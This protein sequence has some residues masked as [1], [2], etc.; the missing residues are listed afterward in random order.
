MPVAHLRSVRCRTLGAIRCAAGITPAQLPAGLSLSELRPRAEPP[1][2]SRVP[3][4]LSARGRAPT[5]DGNTGPRFALLPGAAWGC[6][7]CADINLRFLYD[8]VWPVWKSRAARQLR[9]R[10]RRQRHPVAWNL[11]DGIKMSDCH[12]A[13]IGPLRQD[14]GLACRPTPA[15][16]RSVF[17]VQCSVFSVQIARPSAG[18]NNHCRL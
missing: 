6:R 17:S 15:C 12:F 1:A 13:A 3:A 5:A 7:P 10:R 2:A 14:G 9:A 16:Q 8:C 4:P 18:S 11:R